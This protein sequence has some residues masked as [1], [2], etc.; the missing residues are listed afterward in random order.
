MKGRKKRKKE[1]MN[2]KKKWTDA[3]GDDKMADKMAVGNFFF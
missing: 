1:N 3:I 2:K